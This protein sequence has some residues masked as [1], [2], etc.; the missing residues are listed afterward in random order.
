MYSSGRLNAL[1]HDSKL[2]ERGDDKFE[3]A[4]CNCASHRAG[5]EGARRRPLEPISDRPGQKAFGL[6]L[7][8]RMG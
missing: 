3:S 2:L 5:S 6:G 8:F 1:S 7:R 4:R